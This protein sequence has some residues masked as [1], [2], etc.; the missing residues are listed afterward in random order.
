MKKTIM[1]FSIFV[2][3]F[4]FFVGSVNADN[5]A[6]AGDNLVQKG[7]YDNNRFVAGKKIINK[8]TID[9]LSFIAGKVIELEGTSSYDFIAGETIFVKENVL[10]DIFVAG[11]KITIDKDAIVGRD[12]YIA[13][14]DIVI[15]SNIAG[16]LRLGGNIVDL[17]GIT[18]SKD[19]YVLANEIILDKDTI[20]NGKFSYPEDA[21][22]KGLK[23]ASI[24]SV[25]T[26]KGSKMVKKNEF[27]DIIFNFVVISVL[28]A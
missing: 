10:K 18:I 4:L 23:A 3:I 8:A 15:K 6:D 12:A 27:K 19:A 21:N 2:C 7:S 25:K 24:G 1:F 22:V 14:N 11:N 28:L 5:I 16:C 9:G 20:I 13:G 17:R 26:I